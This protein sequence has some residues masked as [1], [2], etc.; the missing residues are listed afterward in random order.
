MLAAADSPLVAGTGFA[1]TGGDGLPGPQAPLSL[2]AHAI[3]DS[4]TRDIYI[5]DYNNFAVK[6]VHGDT[7]M[8]VVCREIHIQAS[9]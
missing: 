5:A 2:P 9:L 1:G 6:V 8:L 3:M 4:A 7:G